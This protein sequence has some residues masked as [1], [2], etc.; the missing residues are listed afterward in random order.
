MFIFIKFGIELHYCENGY[1]AWIFFK[2]NL[3]FFIFLHWDDLV[4][5]LFLVCFF[6]FNSGKNGD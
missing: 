6:S 1:D 2:K 4:F 3:V 5:M